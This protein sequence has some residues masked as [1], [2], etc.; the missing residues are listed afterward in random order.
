[1]KAFR[2][3]SV[4]KDEPDMDAIASAAFELRTRAEAL[5]IT[6]NYEHARKVG[7]NAR[8]CY[9]VREETTPRDIVFRGQ[10]DRIVMVFLGQDTVAT[11]VSHYGR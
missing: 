7:P 1:M 5:A 2:V 4:W 10:P 11:N 8:C 6:C 3:W 9:V